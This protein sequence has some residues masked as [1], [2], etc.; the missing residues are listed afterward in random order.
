MEENGV[1][2][3]PKGRKKRDKVQY[4]SELF[5]KLGT[6]S[7]LSNKPLQ[8]RKSITQYWQI[9]NRKGGHS[10]NE[11]QF[12]FGNKKPLAASQNFQYGQNMTLILCTN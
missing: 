4:L 2:F 5:H 9:Y 6:S 3:F 12:C 8:K 10:D 7:H 1:D 11:T